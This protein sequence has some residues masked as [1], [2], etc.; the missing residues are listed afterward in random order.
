M[1]EKRIL[2]TKFIGYVGEVWNPKTGTNV[3]AYEVETDAG[4]A[5]VQITVD[6]ARHLRAMPAE[7][8]ASI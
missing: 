5:A 2:I 1:S 8:P 7:L 6:V 4:P 3:L